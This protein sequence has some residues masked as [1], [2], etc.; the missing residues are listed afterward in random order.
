M[1]FEHLQILFDLED[2]SNDFSQLFFICFYIISGCI[3]GSITWAFGVVK[4]LT[5]AKPFGDI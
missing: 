3:F 2:S 4:L 1:V 5:L